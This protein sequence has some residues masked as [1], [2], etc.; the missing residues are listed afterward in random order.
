MTRFVSSQRAFRCGVPADDHGLNA[1]TIRGRDFQMP[2]RAC[3]PLKVQTAFAAGDGAELII[4]EKGDHCILHVHLRLLS[5]DDANHSAP[6][7]RGRVARDRDTH[8][9]VDHAGGIE[10]EPVSETALFLGHDDGFAAVIASIDGQ[11]R[12]VFDFGQGR[13]VRHS[14]SAFP[15]NRQ[16][17]PVVFVCHGSIGGHQT[18]FHF[19][20]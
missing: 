16:G 10:T 5:F 2:D 8:R 1:G 7:E 4:R 13:V 11:S 18:R 19:V 20:L 17:L 6:P 9:D 15:A 3:D 12:P 14:T